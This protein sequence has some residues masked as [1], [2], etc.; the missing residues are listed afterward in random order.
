MRKCSENI[1]TTWKLQI[2]VV[3]IIIIIIINYSAFSITGEVKYI[4][5]PSLPECFY[6]MV[7]GFSKM[8]LLCKTLTSSAVNIQLLWFQAFPISLYLSVCVWL[9][10]AFQ[11]LHLY[12]II[13]DQ[14]CPDPSV[15]TLSMKL[16]YLSIMFSSLLSPCRDQHDLWFRLSGSGCH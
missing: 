15:K 9:F 8:G 10:S 5:Y 12:Q 13:I 14:Y 2:K 3:I 16:L 1:R 11:S 4:F 7:F 6:V